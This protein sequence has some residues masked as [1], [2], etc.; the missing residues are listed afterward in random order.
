MEATSRKEVRSD[1]NL[2]YQI[3]TFRIRLLWLTRYFDVLCFSV[4]KIQSERWML[5]CTG[6]LYG[7][8]VPGLAI[9]KNGSRTFNIAALMP[10]VVLSSCAVVFKFPR[11]SIFSVIKL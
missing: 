10:W 8:D 2:Y 6:H 1:S 7:R 3:R 4:C 11:I 9:L 5:I